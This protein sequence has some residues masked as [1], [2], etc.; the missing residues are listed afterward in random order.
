MKANGALRFSN[1]GLII[2]GALLLEMPLLRAEKPAI[3][4]SAPVGI[5]AE[6]KMQDGYAVIN[7]LIPGS[8]AQLSGLIHSGDRILALAQGDNAFMDARGLT[9][10]KIVEMI[11]GAPNTVLQLQVLPADPTGNALPRTITIPRDQLKFKN[12]NSTSAPER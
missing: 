5:G 6:L 8:P 7:G 2:I 3:R 12:P 9:L 10:Q 11:R 1:S 4:S